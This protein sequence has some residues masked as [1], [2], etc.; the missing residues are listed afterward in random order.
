MYPSRVLTLRQ[1]PLWLVIDA[2]IVLTPFT[3]IPVMT[4]GI[5]YEDEDFFYSSC[6]S[7]LLTVLRDIIN[8]LFFL[9]KIKSLF[10]SV[11][12]FRHGCIILQGEN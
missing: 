1:V 8:V 5:S 3:I 6:L 9:F 2:N 7:C 12:V 4:F 11:H 10:L